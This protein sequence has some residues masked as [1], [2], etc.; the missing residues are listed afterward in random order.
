MENNMAMETESRGIDVPISKL[1]P[2]HER[3]IGK[4]CYARLL[5]SIRAVGLIQPLCV[6]KEGDHFVILS[7]YLRYLALKEL[8]V[9]IVPCLLFK[10]KEAYSFDKMVSH[11]S[12][13]QQTRMIRKAMET[14][15]EKTIAR[16]L[17]INSLSG[18]LKTTLLSRLGP[19]IIKAYDLGKIILSC[20]KSLMFVKPERQTEIL[21]EMHRAGDF[22]P[23][24]TRAMVIKTPVKL[25]AK[26]DAKMKTPWQHDDIKQQLLQRFNEIDQRFDFFTSQYRKYAADLLKLCIYVRKL[27]TN[28]N[29][30]TFM[31]KNHPDVAKLLHSIIFEAVEITNQASSKE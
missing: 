5:A 17:G 31:D 15:D 3:K 20:A 7:G 9:K 30:R 2:L 25:R 8:G 19:D 6:Y 4:H 26:L 13:I 29:L 28:G 14:V 10:M 27:I 12:P 24:F 22:S 16:A 21:K 1:V 23:A 18:R 11:L